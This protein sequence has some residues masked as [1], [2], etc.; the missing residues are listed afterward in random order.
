M[1]YNISLRFKVETV[2]SAINVG[3]QAGLCV[4]IYLYALR[5][6]LG[7]AINVGGQAGL[8]VIIYLYALR[9]STVGSAIN[10]GGQAGLCVIIYLYALRLN[11]RFCHKRRWTGWSLCYNISL[12]FKVDL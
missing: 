9:L 8:C 12:R 2:G 10:V 7:S 1:C 6:N 11:R 3:G 5:L 4:I